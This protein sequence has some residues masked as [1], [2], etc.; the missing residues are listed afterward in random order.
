[1]GIV[2]VPS[3]GGTVGTQERTCGLCVSLQEA[4]PAAESGNYYEAEISTYSHRTKP[5]NYVFN[6]IIIGKALQASF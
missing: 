4:N 2:G 6:I 3:T 5:P 1:M